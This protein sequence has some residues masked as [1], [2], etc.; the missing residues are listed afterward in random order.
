MVLL[1]L[2]MVD[3]FSSADVALQLNQMEFFLVT[4]PSLF[5]SNSK[6]CSPIHSVFPE[7]CLQVI[8]GVFRYQEF[9]RD[10]EAFL[11]LI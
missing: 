11:P 2:K 7:L 10:F 4:P 1:L 3:G 5:I 8:K 6:T 9:G